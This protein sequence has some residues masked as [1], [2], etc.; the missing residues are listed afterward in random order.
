VGPVPRARGVAPSCRRGWFGAWSAGGQSLQPGDC[1]GDLVGPGPALSESEL[2]HILIQDITVTVAGDSEIVD[3]T[4]TWAGGHQ[5]TGQAV[6]PVGHLDQLSCFPVLL[7]RVTELAE[8]GRS[9]R[10][11]AETLNAEGP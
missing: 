11:I 2:L 7:H 4:I 10:Q 3:V 9:S 6:R 5:I 8:A 1:G